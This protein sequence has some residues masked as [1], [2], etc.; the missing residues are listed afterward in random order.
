MWHLTAVGEQLSPEEP[1]AHDARLFNRLRKYVK[2]GQLR[3]RAF[4]RA[5]SAWRVSDDTAILLLA[6]LGREGVVLVDDVLTT[7]PPPVPDTSTPK[8]ARQH[9]ER[10]AGPAVRGGEDAVA[11]ARAVMSRD[12]YS[13]APQN[14]I[15]TALEEVGLGLLIKDGA[16]GPLPAGSMATLAGERKLAAETLFLHNQRLV[17][18]Y[19]VRSPVPMGM[20]QEDLAQYGFMGLIRAVEMFDPY[21]GN[22]FST[23]AGWWIKQR[24]Y[25]GIADDGRLIRVPVHVHEKMVAV[26][27]A[28]SALIE[29]GLAP[30]PTAIAVRTGLAVAKVEEYIRLG[31]GVASFDAPVGDQGARTLGDIVDKPVRDANDDDDLEHGVSRAELRKIVN[32]LNDRE[33]R[34]ITLRFGLDGCAKQTLEEVG[35]QFGVTRERARQIEQ[36]ALGRLG[37]RLKELRRRTAM[38]NATPGQGVTVAPTVPEVSRERLAYEWCYTELSS[39]VLRVVF[40]GTRPLSQPGPTRYKRALQL[41]GL[42]AASSPRSHDYIDSVL[43]APRP[44][45]EGRSIAECIRTGASVASA[46]IREAM[47]SL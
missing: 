2:D 13:R 20:D 11:A 43:L 38:E 7:V 34:V 45:L 44:K 33:W 16:S 5:M 25:R 36:K 39:E 47:A 15:L 23:Y 4:E 9:A 6:Q 3:R 24:I 12:R 46:A 41:A 29:G 31:L 40:G 21:S 8:S 19:A 42:F 35:E 10:E 26:A 30:T 14:R 28:R 22:K 37:R 32:E 17:W 27:R 18:S 1:A